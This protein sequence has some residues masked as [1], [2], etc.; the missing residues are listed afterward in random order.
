MALLAAPGSSWLLQVNEFFFDLAYTEDPRMLGGAGLLT[1]S[2]E[3]L[4]AR[5]QEEPRGLQVCRIGLTST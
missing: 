3:E 1:S 5:S 2:W 4:G